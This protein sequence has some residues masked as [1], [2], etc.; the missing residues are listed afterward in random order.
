MAV[1]S[2]LNGS[3]TYPLAEVSAGT[4]W[5]LEPAVT[6]SGAGNT[7]FYGVSCASAKSCT[8]VGEDQVISGGSGT[9]STLAESWDGAAWTQRTTLDPGVGNRLFAVSCTSAAFCMAVGSYQKSSSGPYLTLGEEWNGTAWA[10]KLPAD[11]PAPASNGLGG[12]SCTS[13]SFCISAGSYTQASDV[14]L[15]ET[16]NGTSWSIQPGPLPRAGAGYG[17]LLPGVSC[18]AATTCAAAGGTQMPGSGATLAEALSGTTWT[19]QATPDPG[20]SYNAL[21]GISCASATSCV[22]V[23]NYLASSGD[24]DP[25]AEAGNPATNSWSVQSTPVPAGATF[26]SQLNSVS[27][28]AAS[29]CEAAGWYENSSGTDVTLAEKWN[30]TVWT[31]QSTPNPAGASANYLQSISCTTA[32]ACTAV[33]YDTNNSGDT[34]TLAEAWNGTTWSIQTTPNPAASPTTQLNGVSCTSA[35]VC[36]AVGSYNASGDTVTLA[37]IWNGTTWKIHHPPNPAGTGNAQLASVSCQ[38]A[39][40]CTAVGSYQDSSGNYL[41]LAETRSG[42]TWSIQTTP[43]PSAAPN[44]SYLTG[45]SAVI[46]RGRELDLAA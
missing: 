44:N 41:T 45:V 21:Y 14:T 25:L 29:S 1:G 28:P 7:Q 42:T 19:Q 36:T 35:S 13:A 32:S 10:D 16:W 38:T 11:Q 2:Y 26:T 30:G 22:A 43:N 39:T 40:A 15:T 8:A 4:V 12:V 17:Y 34:V 3:G 20:S 5:T 6:P 24:H 27:C 18:D 31:V 46:R 33:G 37:E 23:G 9:T